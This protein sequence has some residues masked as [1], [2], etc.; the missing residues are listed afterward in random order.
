MTLLTPVLLLQL[1]AAAPADTVEAIRREARRAEADF[2]RLARRLAPLDFAAYGG[3]DCDEI[4]GR[5]CL[6][7]DTGRPPEPDPE[8]DRVTLARRLAIEALRRAFSF[9]AGELTTSGPLVRYLV[10][11][12]RPREA[13]S[14][15]RTYAALTGDSIWGPLLL[16]F[17]LHAAAEDSAAERLFDEGIA[18]LE[19]EDR[20]RILDVEW[21]LGD[22]DRRLY[23]KLS[24]GDRREY[25][26]ELWTLADPLFLTP[27]NERRAEHIARHVWSRI[28]ARAPRV[29]GMLR[30]A[31]DLD[32]LTVRYGVPYARSR[33]PGTMTREG[34]LIEHFDPDQLAY[35]PE[36]LLA[37]G[38]PPPPLP[39]ETWALENPRTRS[40]HAPATIR[41]L[42]ALPHQ[43]TIFPAG[44]SAIVQVDAAFA[45]DS[46]AAGRFAADVGLW[47]LD[48]GSDTAAVQ[49]S[50]GRARG[51]TVHFRLR[52]KVAPG[53]HLYSAE[54]LEPETRQ[55]G[56][57]RYTI[58][59]VMPDSGVA[60][61]DPL[62]ARP[63][64]SRRPP[65]DRDDP[66]L[67]P[68]T[69]LSLT[70][71]DTVGLYA[72]AH[73]L[74]ST[75]AEAAY[76]VELTV[77]RADR[78]SL[79]ARV[80]SWLGQ[81]LGLSSPDVPPRL[82]WTA[83]AEPDRPAVIAVDLQLDDI[84]EGMQ[85]IQVRVT[86]VATGA[87]AESRRIVRIVR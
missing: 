60:V 83:V 37:R 81:R 84:E 5:F 21:L 69:D 52:G 22:A 24:E 11:D 18:R 1:Q 2:E 20:A 74:A 10:E 46:A 51:D 45:F 43:L 66:M 39:G 68:L 42:R 8:P 62:L 75:G 35:V 3:T 41:T 30:W 7:Y 79:P 56:R 36:D 25:E 54:A 9:Q 15:A 14:A 26:R 87:H 17:A 58:D 23:R 34:S 73:G 67:E 77:R 70:L 27:G 6:H 82:A 38:R 57:A 49:R 71:G 72:E 12:R 29:A 86:D 19:E 53:P 33:S 28:L 48:A 80:A 59:V 32:Q 76:R 50:T 65:A 47:L 85:V 64:G 44:D 13:V 4:V 78:A 55:G 40:G 31:A 61:S 63:F 16:G